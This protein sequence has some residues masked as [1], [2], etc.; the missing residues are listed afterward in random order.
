MESLR[1]AIEAKAISNCSCKSVIVLPK[2]LMLS[3]P[4]DLFIKDKPTPGYHSLT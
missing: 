2:A 1:L 3:D 4:I